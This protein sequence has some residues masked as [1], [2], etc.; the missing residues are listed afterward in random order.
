MEG[1]W[2]LVLAFLSMLAD[3]VR[4]RLPREPYGVAVL[5]IRSLAA[6]F[7]LVVPAGLLVDCWLT[8]WIAGAIP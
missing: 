1:V 5:V 4:G 8:R 2:G 6:G 3:L 7:A